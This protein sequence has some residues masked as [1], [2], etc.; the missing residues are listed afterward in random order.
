MRTR[1]STPE[2][3]S[4]W[5]TFEA[6]AMPYLGDLFRV[7]MWLVH[8][9][10]EAEDLVQETF[11]QALQSFHRFEEG[12]NCRAWLVTIM[13]RARG[14]RLR[15]E[16]RLRLVSE[17]EECIAETT[18]YVPPTPQG[19]TEEEVLR[20]LA[21]LPHQFQEVVV[22]SDVEDL[23]YKEIAVALVLPIGTVM[24]RL[25]RGRQMLR[26]ELAVYANACGIGRKADP[27]PAEL[28]AGEKRRKSDAVQ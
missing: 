1:L 8:N 19:L 23:S 7:A 25:H 17:T 16:T 15:H 4:D 27:Q 10:T 3:T 5:T 26:A 6:V 24:S 11:S 22:L 12:T 18:A 14:L 28:L 20:A 9:R 21:R 13:Y 2:R